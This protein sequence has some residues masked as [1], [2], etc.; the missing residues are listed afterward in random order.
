MLGK[1]PQ[2]KSRGEIE[3]ANQ[4]LLEKNRAYMQRWRETDDRA[5]NAQHSQDRPRSPHA[6][7]SQQS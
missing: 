2:K 7:S 4:D 6:P 3:Q 5:A 1:A